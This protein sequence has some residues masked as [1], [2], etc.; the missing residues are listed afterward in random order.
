M[1]K[2]T[3]AQEDQFNKLGD[4]LRANAKE[5]STAFEQFRQNRDQPKNAVE[6]MEQR[7]QMAQMKAAQEGRVLAAF[8]PLY[9]SL[10]PD[11]KK[12]ADE[13]S[14][15]ARGHRHHHDHRG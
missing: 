9:D 15:M 6:Q 11:Q 10:S 12:A 3:P 13:M 5:R 2:I 1:L 7:E 8:K 4:A 14:S